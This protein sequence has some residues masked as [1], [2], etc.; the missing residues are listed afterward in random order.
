MLL[1]S[2]GQISSM[3]FSATSTPRPSQLEKLSIAPH[4]ITSR[5]K[6]S[7]ATPKK[8]KSLTLKLQEKHLNSEE[9]KNY[10]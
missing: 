5:A 7:Q 9:T 3:A 10:R 6:N 1:N 8:N 4:N 2:I